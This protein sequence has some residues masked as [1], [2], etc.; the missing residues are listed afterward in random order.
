VN[1]RKGGTRTYVD[2]LG[3]EGKQCVWVSR[4]GRKEGMP[5][6]T[7]GIRPRLKQHLANHPPAN[8]HPRPNHPHSHRHPTASG[9]VCKLFHSSLT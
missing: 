1:E 2:A 7:P 3:R 4:V 9:R 8:S 6:V 5:H